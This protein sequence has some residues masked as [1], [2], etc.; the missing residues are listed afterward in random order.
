M[1]EAEQ[2]TLEKIHAA[3]KEAFLEYGALS[4]QQALRSEPFMGTMTA[5]RS[6]LRRWSA[7][8]TII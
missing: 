8:S 4:K 3:A 7:S 5:R 2:T 6:F 1:S